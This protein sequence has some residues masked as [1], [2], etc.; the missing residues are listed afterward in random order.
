VAICDVDKRQR[1]VVIITARGGDFAAVHETGIAS[2][3]SWS[4]RK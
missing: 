3:F 2:L 4:R 1:L